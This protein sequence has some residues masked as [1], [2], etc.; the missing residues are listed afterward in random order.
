M[1]GEATADTAAGEEPSEDSKEH[2]LVKV[3]ANLDRDYEGVK[4]TMY[5]QYDDGEVVVR[6]ETWWTWAEFTGMTDDEL[7][8]SET[9]LTQMN[10]IRQENILTADNI[11]DVVLETDLTF[12]NF[13]KLKGDIGGEPV[14]DEVEIPS[15]EEA[16]A[17]LAEAI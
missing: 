4:L 2:D 14:Y 11:L 10:A 9:G 7:N 12:A 13:G 6:D 16:Q 17:E 1:Q 15:E 5:E 8:I 3:W